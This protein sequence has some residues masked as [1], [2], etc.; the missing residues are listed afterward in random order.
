MDHQLGR[1]LD[2]MD[3]LKLTKNTTIVFVSDHGYHLGAHGLWQKS[4]LFEGSC[5]VPMVISDPDFKAGQVSKSPVGLID[6]YPTLA[7]LT[8]CV[9]PD[10]VKGVSL[11]PVLRDPNSSVQ[12]GTLS[13]TISRA[14]QMH[15]EFTKERVQ[16]YS[17]RT[18]RYRYTS[19]GENSKHGR[20][21]YDY[22]T[23]PEEFTNLVESRPEVVEKLHDLLKSAID[24]ARTK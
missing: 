2:A 22:Q 7:D 1:V 23:D 11:V 20:E 18:A 6:L 8:G 15:K 5:H 10:H 19:W 12:K 4:D 14:R 9:A 3:R 21:L 16:G 13:T 24:G 17:I